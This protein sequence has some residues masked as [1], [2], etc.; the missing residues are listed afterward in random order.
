MRPSRPCTNIPFVA[1]KLHQDVLK[2][3]V[4][5]E[6]R[7]TFILIAADCLHGGTRSKLELNAQNLP[8][9]REGKRLIA[10]LLE[11]AALAARRQ[12]NEAPAKQVVN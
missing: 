12:L 3:L 11:G 6:P 7:N 4:E 9:G 8:P 10:E 2:A 1:N 5:A